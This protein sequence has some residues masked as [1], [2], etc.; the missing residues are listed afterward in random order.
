MKNDTHYLRIGCDF[1]DRQVYA[2]FGHLTEGLVPPFPIGHSAR[3]EEV[4][5]IGNTI[6]AWLHTG[7]RKPSFD[8]GEYSEETPEEVAA[9]VQ[10]VARALDIYGTRL[11]SGDEQEWR[12]AAELTVTREWKPFSG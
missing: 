10:R 5:A 2:I 7:D 12:R 8:V 9:A 1:R 4:T 6:L 3:P 11:L